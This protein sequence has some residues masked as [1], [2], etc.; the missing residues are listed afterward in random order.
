VIQGSGRIDS[1]ILKMIE[2]S[3]TP[4]LEYF[5]EDSC[6]KPINEFY[7]QIFEEIVV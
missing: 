5:S 6:V 1:N 2:E 7:N 4:F 3:E